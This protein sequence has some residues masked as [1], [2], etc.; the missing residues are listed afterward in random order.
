MNPP[1]AISYPTL[2]GDVVKYKGKNYEK[3][4]NDY[5]MLIKNKK[6]RHQDLEALKLESVQPVQIAYLKDLDLKTFNSPIGIR[7]GCILYTYFEGELWLCLGEDLKFRELT[8]FSGGKKRDEL[9]TESA[10]RELCEETLNIICP[11]DF[12]GDSIVLYDKHHFIVFYRWTY[13]MGLLI[14]EF[15]KRRKRRM[16]AGRPYEIDAVIWVQESKLRAMVANNHKKLFK[17]LQLFLAN[18]GDFY[19]YLV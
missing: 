9:V 18:A 2:S 19:Q 13:T 3:Y 16:V 11:E 4:E 1:L 8:D 7:A 14:Q 17:R 15:E 10:M 5:W 12:E 6:A